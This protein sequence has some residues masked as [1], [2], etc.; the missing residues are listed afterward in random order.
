MLEYEHV[1][2]GV[3]SK[4]EVYIQ[5][6]GKEKVLMMSSFFANRDWMDMQSNPIQ[7]IYDF[8]APLN[9]EF[10]DK[11]VSII[12][13]KFRE[14]LQS[15]SMAAI[16]V[17]NPTALYH[18]IETALPMPDS[19]NPDYN[20]YAKDQIEFFR[21]LLAENTLISK[22]QKRM[23]EK[24]VETVLDALPMMTACQL[25]DWDYSHARLAEVCM[26]QMFKCVYFFQYAEQELP[27][28]LERFCIN[29]KVKS[30]QEYAQCI[31]NLILPLDETGGNVA[32]PETLPDYEQVSA[33]LDKL[34]S[35]QYADEDDYDFR[36]LHNCPLYK[37]S[38]GS[39]MILSKLFWQKNYTKVYISNLEPS[40]TRW[41]EMFL[42]PTLRHI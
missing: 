32:V 25:A 37:K 4:T 5:R 39:Y 41:K 14:Q 2:R 34:S 11:I 21:I 13:V 27:I 24:P 33:I 20:V 38:D 19:P 10:A 26:A 15:N 1:F 31:I 35:G 28:H 9:L 18:V 42:F 8:F 16:N 6:I 17:I 3:P 29:N 36:R 7:F 23:T 40:M 12:S 22:R 30:W